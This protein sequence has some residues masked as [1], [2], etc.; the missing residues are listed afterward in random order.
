MIVNCLNFFLEKMTKIGTVFGVLKV[1]LKVNP[2]RALKKYFPR[3]KLSFI[4]FSNKSKRPRSLKKS[5]MLRVEKFS[6]RVRV[7]KKKF[8]G[9]GSGRVEFFF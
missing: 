2:K 6:G 4:R 7:E 9:S 3:Q 5:R 8:S 1:T